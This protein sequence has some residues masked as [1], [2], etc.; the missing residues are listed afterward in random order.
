MLSKNPAIIALVLLAIVCLFLPDRNAVAQEANEAPVAR[1]EAVPDRAE[2]YLKYLRNNRRDTALVSFSLD[3]RGRLDPADPIIIHNP[4]RAMPL[5]SVVK[6]IHLAAYAKAVE[7]GRMD[8]NRLVTVA[9]WEQTYLPGTDG[10]AHDEALRE[11]GIPTSEFGFALNPEQTV[12]VAQMVR[13]MIRFSDNA[14]PDWLLKNLGARAF[15]N[16]LYQGGLSGQEL[17]R[18][19][20]G[21]FLALENHE[22]GLLTEQ[23]VAELKNLTP[24]ALSL[25][26]RRLQERYLDPE[27]RA[28]ELNWRLQ[29]QNQ[30]G[31]RTL[32]K[33]VE[34]VLAKGTAGD[35]A[36]MFIRILNGEFLSN[37]VSAL[38]REVLETSFRVQ[39]ELYE[40]YGSKGGSLDGGVLN[41]ASYAIPAAG[42]FSGKRRVTILFQRNIEPA[43][44]DAFVAPPFPTV[45]FEDRLNTER[46]FAGLVQRAFLLP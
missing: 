30:L 6:I 22:K 4:H 33:V 45:L 38:M 36:W 13:A 25:E 46:R 28:E 44:F 39:P 15:A 31:N 18:F 8:P 41:N 9:E 1:P 17:P 14:V 19:I 40:V 26:I 37:R 34:D 11:L 16:V 20:T 7:D 5:A 23:S 43:L 29:N 42:D 27:W 24:K 32:G 35:Y 21:S 10:F 2:A 3:R 12:T